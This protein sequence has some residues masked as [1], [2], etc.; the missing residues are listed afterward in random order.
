M[1]YKAIVEL[2]YVEHS[3]QNR[4]NEECIEHEKILL[5]IPL[6]FLQTVMEG[7]WTIVENNDQNVD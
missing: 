3:D 7:K 4:I 6:Q 5:F 1:T 2:R